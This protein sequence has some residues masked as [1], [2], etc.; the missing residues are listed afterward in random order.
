[1]AKDILDSYLKHLSEQYEVNSDDVE[2][3]TGYDMDNEDPEFG[4][5]YNSGKGQPCE[6]F[7]ECEIPCESCSC[8]EDDI[9]DDQEDGEIDEQV[10]CAAGITGFESPH[11]GKPFNDYGKD[12]TKK[13]KIGN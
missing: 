2:F 13:I 3:D 4:E 12:F 1:M 5:D 7:C 11:T 6:G 10:S 8:N 9:L